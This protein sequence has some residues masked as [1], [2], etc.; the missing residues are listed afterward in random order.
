[1]ILLWQRTLWLCDGQSGA[2]A[3]STHLCHSVV[4]VTCLVHLPEMLTWRGFIS[5]APVKCSE[6]R[7][8]NHGLPQES[9]VRLG[10]HS[11]KCLTWTLVLGHLWSCCAHAG[12]CTVAWS[13]CRV[14]VAPILAWL[15]GLV[16][17][18]NRGQLGL[19]AIGVFLCWQRPWWVH[20]IHI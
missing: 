14:F 12:P 11:L 15:L 16:Q 5:H 13:V 4:V 2:L 1:M 17:S 18:G 10:T 8:H 9:A 20:Y 19:T 3:V 7:L 6:G